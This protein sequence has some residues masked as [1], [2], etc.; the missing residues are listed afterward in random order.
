MTSLI[1][2]SCNHCGAPIDVPEKS[3][4]VTCAHCDSRLAIKST[5]SANYTEVIEAVQRIAEQNEDMA[6]DL[7]A[8]RVH[9]DIEKLD[10]EWQQKDKSYSH[11]N[12]DGSHSKPNK[13]G[14]VIGGLMSGGFGVYWMINVP[15]P[16]GIIGFFIVIA[17]MTASFGG[18]KK[19]DKYD[20]EK[21]RYRKKRQKLERR[22]R[23][24]D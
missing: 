22:L 10:R 9:K 21:S 3:K 13:R 18:I 15:A 5:G 6:E 11:T 4:F 16:I 20:K 14:S 7:E 24:I 1:S 17:G 12:K 2:L 8:I 23:D 19:A